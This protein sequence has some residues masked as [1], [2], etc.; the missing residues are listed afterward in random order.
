ML[1]NQNKI[2]HITKRRRQLRTRAKIFGTA[3][4]PRLN[5]SKSIN[6]IYLQLIDDKQGKTLVSLH[7]K[8]LK[9]KGTKSEIAK[10]AGKELAAKAKEKKISQCVFDRGASV[11]HGRVKAVAEGARE[12]GLKF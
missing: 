12:G 1:K 10:L 8:F 5:V 7:S 4:I 9:N 11:Y 6:H 3:K 2:K